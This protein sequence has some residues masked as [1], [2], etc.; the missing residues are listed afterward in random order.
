M[1]LSGRVHV[2]A[3]P[4][5]VAADVTGWLRQ[6]IATGRTAADRFSIALSGGST[7]RVLFDD[8]AGHADDRRLDWTAWEVYYADERAC[9]PTDERSNHHLALT[10]LL[11]RVPIDPG[12]VHRME[13][14]RDD[15]GAAAAEYS[16]L[17][18]ATL[19][20][21]PGG[22]PRLDVILLGLGENGHT[23]SLFPGDPVLDV[24]DRWAARSRAD[25][26][27]YDRVTLTYPTI[28]AAAAVAFMVTGAGKRQ[29]FADVAAGTAPAARVTPRDGELH[30]FLDRA[31]AQTV[32]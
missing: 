19:R 24:V 30:W 13:A 6:R 7:P 4:A 14:D 1:A 18:A 28:N 20:A 8:L 23:A 9:P 17:L 2:A 32:P 29:A 26:E 15:L 11:S 12:R 27:P 21:G 5:A 3:D 10:H 31:A 25:Y 16:Q 22:A